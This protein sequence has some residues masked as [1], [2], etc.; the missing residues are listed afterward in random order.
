MNGH[1]KRSLATRIKIMEAAYTLFCAQGYAGT[2][3]EEISQ[4][5]GVALQTVKVVFR[6]KADLLLAT[7]DNAAAGRVQRP[8]PEQEWYKEAIRT[9][10]AHLALALVVEHGTEVYRRLAP[11]M[12]AVQTAASVDERVAAQRKKTIEQRRAGMER[13]IA[14]LHKR[15]Q[16]R[17][18]LDVRRGT[19]I[20]FALHSPECLNA[21]TEGCGWTVEDWKEWHYES[22]CTS[23]LERT[24]ASARAKARDRSRAWTTTRD[25]S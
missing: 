20:L 19:D 2:T 14:N 22:L 15:G 10:E 9:D 4:R 18:D 1:Q 24:S 8:V 6:G 21:F 25:V 5:A 13:I 11:I 16:L 3:L 12:P 23:L 7:I 17:K